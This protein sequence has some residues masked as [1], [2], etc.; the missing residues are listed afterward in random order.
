M[1]HRS[2]NLAHGGLLCLDAKMAC[3]DVFC[4]M[5]FRKDQQY[6]QE[7]YNEKEEWSNEDNMWEHGSINQHN[8]GK[9]RVRIAGS[10]I[11]Q[12]PTTQ[13]ALFAPPCSHALSC[14]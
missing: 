4:V 14:S 3:W 11:E 12:R 13:P 5:L 2:L 8:I 1:K 10:A 7:R 9:G 6:I